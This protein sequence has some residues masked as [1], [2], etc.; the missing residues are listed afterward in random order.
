[1]CDGMLSKLSWGMRR[2]F[3]RVQ[4]LNIHYDDR[5]DTG[6]FKKL[7][8]DQKVRVMRFMLNKN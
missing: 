6:E 3:V 4:D 2:K 7:E 5:R 8:D 1:M